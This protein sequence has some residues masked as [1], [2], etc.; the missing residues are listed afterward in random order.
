[1]ERKLFPSD[2]ATATNLVRGR[3]P[4]RTIRIGRKQITYWIGNNGLLDGREVI[5]FIHGAGGGQYTWSCQKSFFEKEFNPIIIELPG[6]GG[7]KGKGEKEIGRYSDLLQSFIR[8][9]NLDKIFLVGHSMGGAIALTMA[10]NHAEPIAGIVLVGTGAKLNVSPAVLDGIKN[11]FR[12]AVEEITRSAY[13]R[14]APPDL[15]EWAMYDLMRCS[16]EV[17]YDDFLACNRFDIATEVKRIGLPTLILCGN[18]DTLTPMRY[19]QFLHRQIKSSRL[20]ALPNAG[21]MVMIESFKTFNERVRAFIVNLHL[22]R[23]S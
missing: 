2:K 8:A 13:S 1:M 6:H 23:D 18:E 14:K 3:R 7:S 4:V 12:Q 15:I 19:S 21:H 22:F 17:L 10:L 16:P 20:E 9:M 11:N 5:L